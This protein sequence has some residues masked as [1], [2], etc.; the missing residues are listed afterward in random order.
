MILTSPSNSHNNSRG[1]TTETEELHLLCYWKQLGKKWVEIAKFMNRSENWVKNN[2]RRILKRE[3]IPTDL[4]NPEDERIKALIEELSKRLENASN[5][6]VV[7]NEAPEEDISSDG[8]ITAKGEMK[9]IEQ[10]KW[11]ALSLEE[12]KLYECMEV[13][14]YEKLST[15]GNSAIV[16]RGPF[17]DGYQFGMMDGDVKDKANTEEIMSY[18]NYDQE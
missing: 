3:G 10:K 15:T 5:E 16:K 17:N 6:V 11:G 8:S 13:D 2:W 4:H 1:E 9:G 14:S 12:D 18:C 7:D